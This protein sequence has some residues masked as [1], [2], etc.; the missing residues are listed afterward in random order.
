M[1]Y[2]LSALIHLANTRARARRMAN[3]EEHML[4]DL[5]L[6]RADFYAFG[7]VHRPRIKAACCRVRDLA[8]RS[9][10]DG[11]PAADTETAM[12]DINSL[13]VAVIGA[14]PV[15]LAAAAHLI[16][17]GLAV[18]VYKSGETVA[19]NVRDW[20][21][22]RLFSPWSFNVDAAAR[23]L[24]KRHGWQEPRGTI[25][26]TGHDLYE[27]YLKPLA[28]VP[29]M[30]RAIE[31]GARVA[32]ISRHGIDKVASK[33]RGTRAFVLSVVNGDVRRDLARAVIDDRD[34]GQPR[35]RLVPT[36][37]PLRGRLNTRAELLTACQTC[38]A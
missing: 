32:A 13:P 12:T 36:D 18:K 4:R 11:L 34:R 21:H 27:A 17:R 31:T 2:L 37:Y 33:D 30:T 25:Y 3:L 19:A 8:L 7:A 16:E 10:A 35:I 20:G 14:G 26:P 23:T 5:G 1:P 6:R 9:R 29:E 24:L 38:S 28:G 22:V 15:G